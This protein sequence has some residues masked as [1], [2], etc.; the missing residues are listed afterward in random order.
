[1]FLDLEIGTIWNSLIIFV[2]IM[3]NGGS[4]SELMY[5]WSISY[6]T[7]I[8]YIQ[9][10]TLYIEFYI[11]YFQSKKYWTEKRLEGI[12]FVQKYINLIIFY[13]L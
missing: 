8:K 3:T 5:E 4:Y 13:T 1:M 12:I 6:N 9:L 2:R 7:I 10:A 11:D